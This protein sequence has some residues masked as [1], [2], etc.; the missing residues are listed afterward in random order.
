ALMMEKLIRITRIL[1]GV[2]S[3][4][5]DIASIILYLQP[6]TLILTIPM[7]LLLSILL[8]YGR[9]ASDNELTILQNA[10]MAFMKISKPV[11]YM[12]IA[13]FF[14]SLSMSFYLGPKGSTLLR[15]K[16]SEILTK[17]AAMT[18][19]EGIF[20]TAFKDIVILIREKPSENSL[21]GLLIF[22][23]RKKDEQRLILAKE[24]EMAMHGESISFALLKGQI[25]ISKKNSL[26][27]I[28]F[29][30]YQFILTPTEAGI[31]RKKRELTPLELLE[32]SES[33]PDQKIK[34]MTEFY[35]RLS[36]PALCLVIIFLAPPLSM[37]AGKSGKL[38]GLTIG[39]AVFAVYYSIMLYGEN[40]AKIER[41]PHF[42]GSWMAFFVLGIFSIIL[43]HRIN[44]K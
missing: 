26:T 11:V 42:V 29:E 35:R 5:F 37:L 16:V 19:E 2:G 41:L 10:G 40:L 8:T 34:F 31:G 27:E 20:N 1:S 6:E 24:G 13:C 4:I 17:R 14:L 36:L 12:G 23:E 38:G 25:Y 32:A 30:K 39:L 9:M 28:A 33:Q 22:D 44:R 3:S 18:L 43:F 7:A 21:R 15:E